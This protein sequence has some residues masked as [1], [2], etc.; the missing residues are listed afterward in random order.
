[1]DG[2]KKEVI[3]SLEVYYHDKGQGETVMLLH[4]VHGKASVKSLEGYCNFLSNYRLV[5]PDISSLKSLR[6]DEFDYERYALVLSKL[7][8]K[9]GIGSFSIIAYG[10]ATQIFF[11]LSFLTT[12]PNSAILINPIYEKNQIRKIKEI[13][14]PTLILFSPENMFVQLKA[15][16]ILR[17]M[18]QKSRLEIVETVKNPEVESFFYHDLLSNPD[19]KTIKLILS[20]LE[21]PESILKVKPETEEE[22]KGIWQKD[23]LS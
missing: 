10:R 6:N 5:I 16:Y 12:K 13:D 7:L 15:A 4:D 20:F 11:E 18:L 9:L 17:D 8:E 2:L 22:L 21:H 23:K 1:M 3:D 19:E 14:I